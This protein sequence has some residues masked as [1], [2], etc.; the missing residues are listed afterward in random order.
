[1]ASIV[2]S[3]VGN[4]D[5]YSDNTKEEGSII[6]L[7]RYLQTNNTILKKII[8]LHTSET[9]DR[10]SLTKEWLS[11]EF[12]KIEHLI[13]IIAVS[14]LLSED[15]VNLKLAVQE[16]RKSL[17]YTKKILEEGD[18]LEFNASSGTP[19]MKSSWSI[20]QAAGYAPNSSVWQVRNP[21]QIQS[22]Q[23]RVFATDVEILKVEF[24][25]KIIQQQIQDFNYSGALVSLKESI[26]FNERI[27]ALLEY[28]N[29]R[30]AFDFD[31]AF[32]TVQVIKNEIDDQLVQEICS[33]RQKQSEALLKEAY[34]KSLVKLSNKEYSEF[35]ILISTLHEKLLVHLGKRKFLEQQDRNKSWKD[36]KNRLWTSI[37]TYDQGHLYQYL[38]QTISDLEK[39]GL[40]DGLKRVVMM[41][42]INYD[43][44]FINLRQP[45]N[46]INQYYDQRNDIIHELEGVSHIP[47]QD[48]LLSNLKKAIKLITPLPEIS[49]FEKLNQMI[50]DSL[51]QSFS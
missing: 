11:E 35:L 7:L 26:L 46:Y 27:R 39:I 40:K 28:G 1:M 20:L 47:D 43:N 12:T 6:T 42:I 15:P 5:P 16:A 13:E 29:A 34:F 23:E 25:L 33:L 37:K 45:L 50:I 49:P 2:L 14:N 41:A 51:N 31:T 22:G 9:Q 17:D 19:V 30:L 3:F 32:V 8:L 36:I 38:V 4:Q 44:D 21:K 24:D 18:R 10:A 48:I